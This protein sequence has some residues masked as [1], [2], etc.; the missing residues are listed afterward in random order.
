MDHI[1]HH[2]PADAI[3]ELEQF[4]DQEAVTQHWS[5]LYWD[6]GPLPAPISNRLARI[7]R[8]LQGLGAIQQVVVCHWR[9][10]ENEVDQGRLSP[11]VLE[12]LL[13]AAI[14]LQGIA[15]TACEELRTGH[16]AHMAASR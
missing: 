5:D 1:V 12:G 8:A 16:H 13:T 3:G 11:S 15:A 4:T 9:A 7:D 10:T 2:A 6:K 14:A